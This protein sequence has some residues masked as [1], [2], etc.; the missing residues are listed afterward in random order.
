MLSSDYFRYRWSWYKPIYDRAD[1]PSRTCRI[2]VR[3]LP[4]RKMGEDAVEYIPYALHSEIRQTIHTS[5]HRLHDYMTKYIIEGQ[6]VSAHQL[7]PLDSISRAMMK[8]LRTYYPHLPV[9]LLQH[10]CADEKG[11][12][13]LYTLMQ[14]L[15]EQSW[16]QDHADM[17]P[18]ISAVNLLL[19]KL[20]REAIASLPDQHAEKADHILLCVAGGAYKWSLQGFL[21]KHVEGSV[22]VTQ[23]SSYESM[24]VPVT[25]FS[26]VRRQS[27][28]SLLGDASHLILAYGLD[29][30]LVLRMRE[31][32]KKLSARNEAGMLGLLGQNRLGDHLLKRS[33]AR[34]S[35]WELAE[36]SG[37]G[38]WMKW[39][40][41]AKLLDQLLAKPEQH[42]SK[43]EK[44]L[45][46]FQDNFFARWYLDQI[47]GGKDAENAGEPWRQ[48][49]RTLTA[50]RIF[51]E[52]V[53][54]EIACRKATGLWRDI[55][56][57]LM[58][59]GANS[60]KFR[61]GEM[62][63][64]LEPAYEEGR[65]ILIQPDFNRG[66]HCGK[67]ML[68][69]QACLRIEWTDYLGAIAAVIPDG[70][71]AF[72]DKKFIPGIMDIT[73]QEHEA[74][75]DDFSAA[76]MTIRGSSVTLTRVGYA[77]RNQL[78]E[79][80]HDI[81]G[82]SVNLN[83]P[84]VSIC[85]AAMG[86]WTQ[87]SYDQ[88]KL[89]KGSFAFGQA[90]AQASSGTSCD[91]GVGRLIVLRD[92]AMNLVPFGSVRV[93]GVEVAA[94]RRVEL[95]YN[96]G[97]A[98]TQPALSEL[99]SG[100]RKSFTISEYSLT[101]GQLQILFPRH[102]IP[103]IP[104]ELIVFSS[105]KQ[106]DEPPWLLVQVGNPTLAGMDVNIFELLDPF[107]EVAHILVR[108]GLPNWKKA[109]YR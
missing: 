53:K 99:V 102:R 65:I 7:P 34:L 17:A 77:I 20:I 36:L 80:F 64:L 63:A 100:L 35:L 62:D 52:D 32:R 57:S 42:A 19:L 70:S 55:T 23:I 27:Q 94:N 45:Q 106:S 66:L 38:I 58:P 8:H 60:A 51:E 4:L 103:S 40:L 91:G 56:D 26:F 37:N 67:A 59:T 16:K 28:D 5:I 50:F 29:P 73:E 69:K 54:V 104:L 43:L 88:K 101:Q 79:W 82:G 3:R 44:A 71:I 84:T 13:G 46:P 92:T 14:G 68:T 87:V 33:W 31:L 18:W 12:R 78:R 10:W 96:N 86:D 2:D 76:G 41:D 24:I 105:K 83:M 93:E 72:I 90:L 75:V 47:K 9:H 109:K 108:D 6:K 11:G 49:D 85:L 81:Q 61:K 97:F 98:I 22:E 30:D 1:T 95:L 74:F 39:V 25:P 48:D 89:G 107:S 15:W 21:K